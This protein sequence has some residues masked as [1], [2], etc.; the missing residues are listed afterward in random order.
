MQRTIADSLDFVASGYQ[1]PTDLAR[2][3][4]HNFVISGREDVFV[5]GLPIDV[6][7]CVHTQDGLQV[8]AAT[9]VHFLPCIIQRNDLCPQRR[10]ENPFHVLI[11]GLQARQN[12]LRGNLQIFAL[13]ASMF[14]VKVQELNA[15]AGILYGF[16]FDKVSPVLI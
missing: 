1:Q 10:C 4:L 11:E 6:A 3:I 14:E 15:K 2:L 5:V 9:C 7:M 12:R 16:F 13:A 8:D